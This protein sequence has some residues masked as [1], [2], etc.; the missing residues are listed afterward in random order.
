MRRGGIGID[1]DIIRGSHVRDR[2]VLVNL[3]TLELISF[4][5]P[6]ELLS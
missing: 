2:Q 1:G 4:N 5:G 3:A 6:E